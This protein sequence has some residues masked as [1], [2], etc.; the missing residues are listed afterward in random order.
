MENSF[1][2]LLLRMKYIDRWGL[3]RNTFSDNLAEHSLETAVIAYQLCLIGNL[4]FQKNLDANRCAV[5]ALFHDASE[6]I[7]GD[8]PTPVKYGDPMLKET[9]KAMEKRAMETLLSHISPPFREHYQDILLP[10]E[11]D[12]PLL[13]YLK[14][15]DKLSALIKCLLETENGNR[16]FSGA[17]RSQKEALKA[18]NLPEVDYFIKQFIPPFLKTLDEQKNEL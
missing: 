3:M 12:I 14:A 4:C 11:N 17:L 5:L 13:A 2:A 9:Y 6:I 10:K 16:E 1:F 18:M 15:A 8:M 7:T